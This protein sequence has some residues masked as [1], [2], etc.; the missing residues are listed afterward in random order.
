MR[1]WLLRPR[2]LQ[3]GIEHLPQA[4]LHFGKMG[5]GVVVE[6]HIIAGEKRPDP[7]VEGTQLAGGD[8]LGIGRG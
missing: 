6:L 3:A 5:P 4:G 1:N 2:E 8:R 7:A